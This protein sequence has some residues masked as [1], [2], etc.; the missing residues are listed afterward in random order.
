M[1]LEILQIGDP[2]LLQKSKEVKDFAS[3]S[4]KK[5][6]KD[7]IDTC[8]A[9]KEHTAGL[10]A[11]QVGKNLRLTVIKRVDIEEE[12]EKKGEKVNKTKP[13]QWEVLINPEVIASDEKKA[14]LVW[15]GCLSIG[16]GKKQ[17]WGPVYRP[18]WVK[19]KYQDLEGKEHQL[20]GEGFFSHLIQ[21]EIDHLDGILFTSRVSNP[22]RNLW[23]SK[24]LDKYIEAKGE[25]PPAY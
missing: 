19:I 22:E 1:K 16:V 5:L 13:A 8:E 2:R 11:P 25:F 15:E 7:M 18:S 20:K 4:L 23:L 12:L 17:I 3:Q 6:V 10:A 24:E 9:G 21:H 14:S